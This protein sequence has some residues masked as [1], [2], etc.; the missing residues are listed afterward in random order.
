MKINM[1]RS[2]K[3][4]MGCLILFATPFAGGGL[5]V[6]YL[7][8]SMVLGWVEVLS[9]QEVPARIHS[10]E[11]IENVGDDSVTYRVEAHYEYRFLGDTY[12]GYRVS[13]SESADNVGSFHE[14]VYRELARYQESEQ[15]FRCFVNPDEPSEAILYRNLRWG[16]L[17]LMLVFALVFGGVGFGLIIGAFIGQRI[18]TKEERL[19]AAHPDEP[20]LWDHNWVGGR[21]RGGS[22]AKAIG[23]TIFATIW[24]LISLP[25]AFLIWDEYAKG[26]TLILLVLLFPIVGIFMAIGAV[27]LWMQYFKFNQSVFEMTRFPGILGGLLQ[28]HILTGMKETPERGVRL[29]LS[30]VRM[31]TSGSGKNKSTTE[32][33][34]WQE[35]DLVDRAQLAYTP[36]GWRIPVEM[37]IWYDAGPPSSTDD[38][39]DSVFWRLEAEAA[40]SGVDFDTDFR[41]PVFR[42]PDSD[43][44]FEWEPREASIYTSPAALEEEL[45]AAGIHLEPSSSGGRRIVFARARNKGAASGLTLF[46]AIWTGAIW[47][48]IR[49]G[50][51][52][53][54]PI[55]FGLFEALLIFA[56]LDMW[57]TKRIIEVNRAELV[58]SKGMLRSGKQRILPRDEIESIKPTRGMQSGSKLYYQIE[59]KARGGKKHIIANQIGSLQ[60][61]KSLIKEIEGALGG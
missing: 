40:V 42:T 56:A 20:W 6:G 27:R 38:D 34:L 46:L 47:L 28:G 18:V 4:G 1:T 37:G 59:V 49:F 19:K 52:I 50:A 10:A 7:A 21:I 30:C 41:V 11:L 44:E 45:R 9:W 39:D 12:Q 5:F 51:P 8:L 23:I 24:N 53:L 61:A 35:T 15:T 54:F 22:K 33:V 58:Y 14:D 13:L 2:D 31:E 60:I 55:F 43:P 29:T 48:M 3:R 36:N 57:L 17:G 32:R 16:L 26:N 25:P